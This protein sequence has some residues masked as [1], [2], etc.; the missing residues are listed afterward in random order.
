MQDILRTQG[1][2]GTPDLGK[3]FNGL[4]L[5]QSLF[6]LD[7]LSKGATVTELIDQIIVVGGSEHFNELDDVGVVDF[8]EDGDLVVGE[9][10]EFGSVFELLDVHYFYCV[11]LFCFLV[12]TFV[13]VAVL[14]LADFLQQDVVLDDFVHCTCVGWVC[15][16]LSEMN[17]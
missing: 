6:T 1:L 4:F 11:E 3:Y 12:L 17:F 8:G 16:M 13:Y 9:L 2:K 15:W 10:R 14:P 7:I 5:S